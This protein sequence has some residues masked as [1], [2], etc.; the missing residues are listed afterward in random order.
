MFKT[1]MFQNDN[2]MYKIKAGNKWKYF[3]K[4]GEKS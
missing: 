2:K 4:R 1:K 3:G